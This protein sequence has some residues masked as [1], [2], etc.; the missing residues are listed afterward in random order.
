MKNFKKKNIE[1]YISDI[2]DLSKKLAKNNN[3]IK[4]I[5]VLILEFSKHLIDT[6]CN[7]ITIIKSLLY[8]RKL[9]YNNINKRIILENLLLNLLQSCN[10]SAKKVIYQVLL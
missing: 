9:I 8:A 4:Y 10:D 7:Y 5:D 6:D 1:L 2:L 3:L